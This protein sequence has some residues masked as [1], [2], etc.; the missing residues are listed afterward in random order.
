M[1]EL[2]SIPLHEKFNIILEKFQDINVRPFIFCL[3]ERGDLLSQWRAYANDGKGISIGFERSAFHLN[4]LPPQLS[5]EKIIN[6]Y[7]F[8]VEYN[9]REQRRIIRNKL[10]AAS[11]LKGSSIHTYE[12]CAEHLSGISAIFKN[13]AFSEEKEWRLI[14]L[15]K[16][17]K[18]LPS[19]QQTIK[20]GDIHTHL[21]YSVNDNKTLPIKQIHLG[22]NCP[23]SDFDLKIFLEMNN[24]KNVTIKKSKASYKSSK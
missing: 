6:P 11:G 3:S 24:H 15:T 9:L 22:P 10:M 7:L 13:S 2:D 5:D 14:Y 21:E 19:M 8:K 16:G 20:N 12:T 23:V 4:N 17:K 1:R 18:I